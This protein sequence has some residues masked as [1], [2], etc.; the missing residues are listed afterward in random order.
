MSATSQLKTLWHL[1]AARVRGGTHKERLE[2]F[3]AGQAEGYD[4]FRKKLLHGREAMIGRLP[5]EPGKVWVDIGAGTGANAEFVGE[6]L[7]KLSRVYQVDLCG[8][9]LEVARRRAA[10]RG[11]TNITA[12]EADATQFAPP[13]LADIVTFS[14]S[15]TMIPDWFAAIEQAQRILKPGGTI[16]VVDFFVARKWAESPH[17]KHGW[18]TR[19]FW[20]T[21]FANDNVFLSADHLPF[22]ERHF[23]TVHREEHLGKVPFMP[24][25]KAPYYLYLGRKPEDTGRG[26]RR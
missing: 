21:W 23:E 11:W 15:L 17:A 26:H 22:L 9:L 5:W 3:Y 19:T 16:G 13:E 4:D 12:V 14:Y 7:A 2:S 18:F 25:V 8:P 10:D 20:P 1:L 6:P 24:L